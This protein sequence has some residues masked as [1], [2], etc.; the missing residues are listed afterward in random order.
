[1]HCARALAWL[2]LVTAPSLA[3]AQSTPDAGVTLRI[4]GEGWVYWP[5]AAADEPGDACSSPCV[6]E[7]PRGE[8]AL[9]VAPLMDGTPQYRQTFELDGPTIIRVGR[10]SHEGERL[11]GAVFLGIGGT[12]A[13]VVVGLGAAFGSVG[14]MIMGPTGASILA[15]VLAIG[16]PF[17]LWGDGPT[18]EVEP[19]RVTSGPG[20]IGAGLSIA[21]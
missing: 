21:L 8:V 12:A 7:L 5:H 15:L 2:A 1:L 16:I 4:E 19:V 13:L 6:V 17:V 3:M 11:F 20:D 18:F 10:W 9:D 14:W